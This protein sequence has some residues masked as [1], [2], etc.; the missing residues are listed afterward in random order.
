MTQTFEAPPNT[1]IPKGKEWMDNNFNVMLIGKHG[2]GKTAVVLDLCRQEGINL[3]YFSCSTLDPFV[4]LVGVPF[5]RTD[6]EGNEYLKMVRQQ[7]INDAEILFLDEFNRADSKVHNAI[8]EI[9]QFKSLNGEPLPNL[10]MVW[11]AMNPPT[12]E[13][14]VEELDPAL[15]DRF[16]VFEDVPAKPSAEYLAYKGIRMPIAQALVSWHNDQN[17]PKRD[18]DKT[19]TPRRLEKI[20]KVYEATGEF[21]CAIPL[22]FNTDWAKLRSMLQEAEAK[23][24]AE[25]ITGGTANT[26]PSRKFQYNETYLAENEVEVSEHLRENPDDLETHKTVAKILEPRKADRLG[27]VYA[28]VLDAL[29]PSVLEAFVAGL[30]DGKLDTL[31][32]ELDGSDDPRTENLRKVVTDEVAHRE[33]NDS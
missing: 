9:I 17:H 15:V 1:L 23:A 11:A 13:Y 19:V 2:V 3:K 24:E 22:W 25:G 27:G 21:K 31:A 12:G 18:N 16:D 10:R 28:P 30:S 33:S 14:D 26:G 7:N 8:F 4:D 5:A 32:K 6:D 29:L 20:G